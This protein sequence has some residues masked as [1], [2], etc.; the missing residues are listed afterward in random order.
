MNFRGFVA[1]LTAAIALA[2]CFDFGKPSGNPLGAPYTGPHACTLLTPA[3]AQSVIGK[4][5]HRTQK[6]SPSSVVTQ[7]QYN[8]KAG[9]ITVEA[10]TWK[11]LKP[12]TST[13]PVPGVGDQASADAFALIVRKGSRAISID[14]SLLG[15]AAL[16]DT[17]GQRVTREK[18]LA[19]KLLPKL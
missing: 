11:W 8:G 16:G 3:I 4:D 1:A 12:T 6:M 2:G 15:P 7:C 13:T 19:K 17:S 5:A 18:D 14:V 9:M 10:G